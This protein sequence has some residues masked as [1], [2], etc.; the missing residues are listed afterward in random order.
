MCNSKDW[1][2]DELDIL[3]RYYNKKS[4]RLLLRILGRSLSSVRNKAKR[5]S[6]MKKRGKIV[7]WIKE[8]DN[9]IKKYFGKIKVKD[10]CY[11]FLFHRSIASVFKEAR[12]LGLKSNRSFLIQGE[13]NPFWKKKH[14]SYFKR[15]LSK[16]KTGRK[17]P[18]LLGENNPAKRLEVR[19]KIS[20]GI[21]SW[22]L[23]PKNYR[24][25][26]RRRN[27]QSK[28]MCKENFVNV[29]KRPE[30]REKLRK[31]TL[32]LWK[33][34]SYRKKVTEEMMKSMNMK[35]TRPEKI[36]SQI[37]KFNNLDFEYVGNGKY[38]LK[39]YNPDFVSSQ[40]KKVIE[41]N[42]EYWHNLERTKRYFNRKLKVFKREG[43]KCLVLW[44]FE[45][46]YNPQKVTEK[47]INF[48]L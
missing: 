3:V 18:L 37:V 42:G 38:N 45:I 13:N 32:K 48:S 30:I 21:K 7:Y 35:P 20:K 14:T 28:T 41:V 8:E 9:I 1:N 24:S 5:L 29:S 23:N 44:E 4:I 40:E 17:N 12:M 46:Y 39:G 2:K 34:E 27:K 10:I 25:N 19:K 6:L 16:F 43:V 26:L 33:N 22:Y 15:K 31:S 11:Y 47:L 36:V